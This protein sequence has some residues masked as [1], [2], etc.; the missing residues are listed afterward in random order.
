[1]TQ[2][3]LDD[4]N[5]ERLKKAADE[6]GEYFDSVIILAESVRDGECKGFRC[7]SGSYYAQLGLLHK[8]KHDHDISE[9]A[10]EIVYHVS[11]LNNNNEDEIQG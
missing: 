3:E 11:E 9:L 6:L 2:S 10:N 1:M 4:Q 5:Q 7:G 8:A